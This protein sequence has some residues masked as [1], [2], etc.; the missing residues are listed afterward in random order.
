MVV[1]LGSTGQD[2]GWR[3][4]YSLENYHV[5]SDLCVDVLFITNSQSDL[6]VDVLIMTMSDQISDGRRDGK[7]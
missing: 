1:A 2:K 7:D 4:Q 5:Q 3:S 6:C